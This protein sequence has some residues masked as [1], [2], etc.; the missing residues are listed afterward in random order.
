MID[1]QE[2]PAYK[3][4]GHENDVHQYVSGDVNG[5]PSADQQEMRQNTIFLI[6]YLSST[7]KKALG[8]V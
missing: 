2:M 8:G 6:D 4:R 1:V 7:L 3:I 5:Q